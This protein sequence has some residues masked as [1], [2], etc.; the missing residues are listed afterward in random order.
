MDIKTNTGDTYLHVA[1]QSDNLKLFKHI[2]ELNPFL[3]LEANESGTYPDRILLENGRKE[4]ATEVRA[5]RKKAGKKKSKL[6]VNKSA[7][8]YTG[9]RTDELNQVYLSYKT[10]FLKELLRVS[11]HEDEDEDEEKKKK[12]K[13]EIF[14][15]FPYSVLKE[16][17]DAIFS[18][19]DKEFRS[20]E[21]EIMQGL[22]DNFIANTTTT[23][24]AKKNW[25]SQMTKLLLSGLLTILLDWFNS[26]KIEE[27]AYQSYIRDE[28]DSATEANDP[29]TSD[30]DI[31]GWMDVMWS[32][33]TPQE[34]DEY[35]QEFIR[36]MLD[37]KSMLSKKARLEV[38]RL[39]YQ[40]F[41]DVYREEIRRTNP[42]LDD[43]GIKKA[44]RELWDNTITDEYKEVYLE[45]ART[46]VL[47]G[48]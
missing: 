35:Y 24:E 32:N 21:H 28:F 34:R 33:M 41:G 2:Y 36:A 43:D 10:S 39:A 46:Q 12:Q 9:E 40:L 15:R 22:H 37:K 5:F 30:E 1:A 25:I 29:G 27:A 11:L 18:G 17:V 6:K 23:E 48:G 3:A 13:I 8:V 26:Q 31:K 20:M 7:G 19:S 42:E 47:T 16:N 4:L 38:K 44:V 14:R 45:Q